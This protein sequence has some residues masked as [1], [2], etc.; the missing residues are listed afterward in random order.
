MKAI[1]L[2]AGQ[3]RRLLPYTESSPKCL[4][5]LNNRHFIE[6]QIDALLEVGVEQ[7]VAVVGYAAQRIE[8]ILSKRYS[9]KVSFVYNP[10]YEIADNLASC[11][12]AREHFKH[13]F[14]ILNGDTLFEPAVITKLLS[15]NEYPITLA[16]DEKDSYD[17]DDMKVITEGARLLSVGK[18]LAMSD[19]NG[20][21]I[22]VM[23]FNPEG[24][25][26]FKNTIEKLMYSPDSLQKWYLSIIDQLAANNHVGT[27]SIHGLEWTEVDFIQDLERAQQLA[28]KW[29]NK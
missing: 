14:M 24:A 17:D 15:T 8:T 6:W 18:K 29:D 7:I 16:T 12:M 21:S 2:C 11:W 19:V 1:I 26:L 27:C 28:E 10:F 4:L 3:G 20:E 22:G 23:H 13:D 5:S 25:I 9:D